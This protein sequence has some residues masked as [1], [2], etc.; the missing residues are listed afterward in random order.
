MLARLVKIDLHRRWRTAPAPGAAN[1]PLIETYLTRFPELGGVA[2]V[3]ADLIAEEFCAR[4]VRGEP[5]RHEEYY[6]R[7]PTRTAELRAVLERTEAELTPASF[8]TLAALDTA[9][10]ELPRQPESVTA[11]VGRLTLLPILAPEHQQQA[12]Q[13]AFATRFADVAALVRSCATTPG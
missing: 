7:F 1:R 10:T 3:P 4:R 9:I 2:Q 12:M 8:P 5:A 13:A 6:Q 11:V